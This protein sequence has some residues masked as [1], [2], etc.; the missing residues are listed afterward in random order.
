MLRDE[1]R[2]PIPT[3]LIQEFRGFSLESG[4]E[5]GAH[6]VLLK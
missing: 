4:D 1:D 6:T 3:E 5:L 2:L